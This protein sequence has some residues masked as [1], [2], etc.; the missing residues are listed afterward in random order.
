MEIDARQRQRSIYRVTVAGTAINTLLLLFKFVA[1][2]LGHSSAMIADA[3]HSLSDFISDLVVMVFIHLSSKPKDKDH[4]YGHGKYETLATALIGLGLGLVGL[5]L[6]YEGTAKVVMALQGKPLEQPGVIALVAAVVSIAL[7]EWAYR[8]TVRVGDRTGSEAVVANAWHHR[9]D[10]FSS[11]GTG[12]G[13]GGAL[14]LGSEWAVLDPIAAIIVSFLI[15]KEAYQLCRKA[16][17]ELLEESLSD[18]VEQE[19]NRIVMEEPQ[20]SDLHNLRTRRIGNNVVID[21][22]FRMPG[23]IT[24][25]AAHQHTLN[26]ERRLRDRFGHDAIINIHCE[27]IKV[28]GSYLKT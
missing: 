5:M 7:K 28:N 3:V 19:I 16:V 10:A 2:V 13:I 24:L 25:N 14:L 18:E 23:T 22:H 21:M 17:G 26:I 15:M 1:G 12:L 11:V 4:D 9:S 20:V 6:L 27:P 8:F